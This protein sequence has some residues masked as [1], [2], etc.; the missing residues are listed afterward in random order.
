VRLRQL[1][2]TDLLVWG[3]KNSKH[4]HRFI[5][6]AVY[7]AFQS[8]AKSTEMVAAWV[9]DLPAQLNLKTYSG[10]QRRCLVFCSPH[11]GCDKYLP[12]IESA[13]YIAHAD[14]DVCPVTGERI[15]KYSEHVRLKSAI[16]WEVFRRVY[17]KHCPTI[18]RSNLVFFNQQSKRLVMPWATDLLP[19]QIEKTKDIVRTRYLRKALFPGNKVLFVGTVWHRNEIVLSQFADVCKKH[20]LQFSIEHIK[21]V[22]DLVAATYSCYMAPAIQG[23]GHIQSQTSFYVPC[24]IFKNISYGAL[25][26]TNNPGVNTILGR[27]LIFSRDLTELVTT[28]IAYV[29]SFTKDTLDRMLSVME[30]VQRFH[31]YVNRLGRCV[32]LLKKS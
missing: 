22:N 11:Y 18:D 24:R 20:G 21:E 23:T 1:G 28:Y 8:I 2:V 26:V 6:R 10:K 7:L 17:D 15:T 31:T 9:D 3:L 14:L 16:Y 13:Y 30:E 25:G 32:E 27:Q 5:H 19:H 29:R 4:S 12:I